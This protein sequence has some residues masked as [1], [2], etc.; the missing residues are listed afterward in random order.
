MQN[1]A[2]IFRKNVIH[3][4]TEKG[5]NGGKLSEVSRE[6]AGKNGIDRTYA[7]ALLNDDGEKEVPNFSLSKV[8]GVAKA[9]GVAVIDLFDPDGKANGK[10]AAQFQHVD[11]QMLEEAK[12]EVRS[13]TLELGINNLRFEAEAE[14]FM[15]QAKLR[16]LD[17]A[18]IISTLTVMAQKQS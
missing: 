6:V 15:Y 17:N 9:L 5:W 4:V 13:L 18:K 12:R 16:N 1:I 3:L 8:E 11:I 14:A 2:D 10:N 7:Y